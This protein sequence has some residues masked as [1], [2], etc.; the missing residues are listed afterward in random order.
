MT[1]VTNVKK[2]TNCSLG[3]PLKRVDDRIRSAK[4]HQTPFPYDWKKER[5]GTTEPNT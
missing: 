5:Y 2:C 1:W 3:D 4:L